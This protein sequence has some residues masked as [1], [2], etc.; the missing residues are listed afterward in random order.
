MAPRM[1]ARRIFGHGYGD[2]AGHGAGHG[3]YGYGH[4][5]GYGHG[6][7]HGVVVGRVGSYE[8]HLLRPWRIV[9]V[10]CE[11]HPI[12]HWTE[13]WAEYSAEVKEGLTAGAVMALHARAMELLTP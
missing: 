2:G 12:E 9:R 7:G 13:F 11:T 10:G 1:S 3:G 8:V 5:G 6:H 4:G